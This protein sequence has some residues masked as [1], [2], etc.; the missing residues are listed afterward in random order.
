MQKETVQ[1]ETEEVY[2]NFVWTKL[3]KTMKKM[4]EEDEEIAKFWKLIILRT[5]GSERKFLQ[6]KKSQHLDTKCPKFEVGCMN[7]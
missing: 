2:K 1:K 7:G 4:V 5:G 6:T 3:L